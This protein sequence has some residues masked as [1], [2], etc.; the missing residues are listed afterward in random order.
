[1]HE[2]V[3]DVTL[4]WLPMALVVT[5]LC[6]V[7][8]AAVFQNI[9][10]SA[11]DPQIQMAEDAAALL[12]SGA[13]LQSVLPPN[14]VDITSSLAPYL[15]VYDENGQAV[16]SSAQLDGTAPAIPAGVFAYTRDHAEDRLTWQPREGVRSAI[17]V[18]H[19]R[20]AAS[21]FVVAGRSLREVERQEDNLMLIVGAAWL[22]SLAATL[23]ASVALVYAWM[24][25]LT[26]TTGK[27]V[28]RATRQQ[29]HTAVA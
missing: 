19:F 26:A 24:L 9:R 23:A 16:A 22:A 17:V 4:K 2:K 28:W 6:G 5:A 8:Y 10:Q 11:N 12:A 25:W 13:P 20:G 7:V 21:G 29:Q 27:P 14:K 3:F 15:I 1:M 18:T